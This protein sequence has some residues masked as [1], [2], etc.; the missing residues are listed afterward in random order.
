MRRAVGFSL[1]CL[2]GCFDPGIAPLRCSEAQ[3]AC[4]DGLI[5]QG[6]MCQAADSVDAGAMT[7]LSSVDLRIGDMN[8]S[9]C[10]SGAGFPI[11]TMGCWACAGSFSPAKTASSLCASGYSLPT[12]AA[13]ISDADCTKIS[14][15]FFMASVYG[16]SSRN[17]AD[18]NLSQCGSFTGGLLEPGFF[19]C[20]TAQQSGTLNPSAACNGFRQHLQCFTLNGLSCPRSDINQSTNTTAT[21]GVICCN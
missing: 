16:A 18:P 7:D 17:F 9:G 6:G 8:Q 12:N 21:N 20:G 4:P 15:G 13:K 5:C 11:G 1:V 14:G 10:A 19:G 3:P 2:L